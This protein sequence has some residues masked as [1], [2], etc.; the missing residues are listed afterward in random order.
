MYNTVYTGYALPDCEGGDN[1]RTKRTGYE[2]VL[3]NVKNRIIRERISAKSDLTISC[4]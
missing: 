3:E 1:V 2:I 4:Y